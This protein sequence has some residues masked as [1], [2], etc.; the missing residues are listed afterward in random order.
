MSDGITIKTDKKWR[1]L[2]YGHELPV[3]WRREFDWIKNDEEYENTNFVKVPGKHVWYYAVNEFMRIPRGVG[4]G[5]PELQAWDGYV[6]DSY[7]SGV[8]IK[9]SSDGERYKICR[10]YS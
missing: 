10:F 7:S 8:A 5:F 4:A 1:N 2:L 3:K 9:L 6:S